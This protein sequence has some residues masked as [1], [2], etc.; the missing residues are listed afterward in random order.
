MAPSSGSVKGY[1]AGLNNLGDPT[2]RNFAPVVVSRINIVS[3]A[4]LYP[5]G[6]RGKGQ[7]PLLLDLRCSLLDYPISLIPDNNQQC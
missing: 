2:R 6:G 4:L 3:L 1:F 7:R 5:L